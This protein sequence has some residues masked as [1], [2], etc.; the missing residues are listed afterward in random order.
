MMLAKPFRVI[1]AASISGV[2][3][4]SAF[5]VL[6]HRFDLGAWTFAFVVPLFPVIAFAA[7]FPVNRLDR[8]L[9]RVTRDPHWLATDEGKIW[10]RSDEG[11]AWARKRSSR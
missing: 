4:G 1:A 6:K 10:L 7:E 2:V 9:R 3:C 11:R 5:A 8:H